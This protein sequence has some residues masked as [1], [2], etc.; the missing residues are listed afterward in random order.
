MAGRCCWF[1]ARQAGRCPGPERKVTVPDT[2]LPSQD[3]AG[4]DQARL[5]MCPALGPSG[6]TGGACREWRNRACH[7]GSSGGPSAAQ[8]PGSLKSHGGKR[9][10]LCASEHTAAAVDTAAGSTVLAV[11][12]R[13]VGAEASL[14][15]TVS[16]SST[17][18]R[19]RGLD[20]R[21]WN[22]A[23]WGLY[24]AWVGGGLVICHE[25]FLWGVVAALEGH[26]EK[27]RAPLTGVLTVPGGTPP[28]TP[29]TP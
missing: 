24:L 7:E 22:F 3:Q 28:P 6:C 12:A 1:D 15:G 23:S 2:P 21:A 18:L 8:V 29:V 16:W 4:Q 27:C 5:S 11:L 13:Q 17:D 25:V 9:G 19:R 26:G 10:F 14:H 20:R